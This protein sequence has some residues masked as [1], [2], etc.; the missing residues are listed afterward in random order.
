MVVALKTP[1]VALTELLAEREW[2]RCFPRSQDPDVLLEAFTYWCANYV[3]IRHPERGRI[4]FELRPAQAQAARMWLENRYT[5]VLKARQIGFST[6]I[7]VFCLWLAFGWG[8]RTIPMISRGEREASKL[9]EHAKYALR[10]LPDWMQ[11]KGPTWKASATKIA[12]GNDSVLESLPSASDPARGVTAFVIVVDEIGFLP[13]SKEAWASIEPVVDVGGRAILLGTANGEGNLLHELWVAAQAGLNRFKPVFFGW[14]ANSDRDL[15]WYEAKKADLPDWQLAQEYPTSPE[16]AFL[17]SGNPV[18]NVDALRKQELVPGD[19][20]WLRS[21]GD[22]VWDFV[23][24]GGAL[25]VWVLPVEGGVYAVGADIAQ[26]FD[27]GDFTSAHVIDAKTREVVAHWHGHIDPDVFGEQVLPALGWFYN[28]ALIGVEVNNHGLTTLKGLQRAGY[29]NIY[30]QHR[31]GRVSKTRTELLGWRTT[32]TTKPLMIDE[33]AKEIRDLSLTLWDAETVAELKTYVRRGDGKMEGSP[34]D[35]RVISLAIA[36]QM[37]KHVWEPVY[38]VSDKPPPGTM[39]FMMDNLLQESPQR[40]E[41]IGAAA[42]R[43]KF[44][45]IMR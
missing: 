32:A 1:D 7:S 3:H 23:P 4:L 26:G 14:D 19:T 28:Y 16:E 2:R 37:L 43:P 45:F 5:V 36:V 18:F 33:L 13:N 21:C 10:F 40:R 31:E 22:N 29:R 27:Y 42:V 34:H 38:R 35:D 44:N 11:V 25:E 12:F 8:N 9:L 24:E 6:L 20:G 39:G 41:P 30:R 15:D 17:R